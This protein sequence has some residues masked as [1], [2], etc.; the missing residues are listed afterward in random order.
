MATW[1]EKRIDQWLTKRIPPN[2]QYQL[3]VKNT[4]IL[5]TRFGWAMLGLITCLFVL[6]TN[7]Q[8]NVILMF[9]Y[10]VFAIQLLS[11]FHCYT[12]FVQYHVSFREFENYYANEN[13]YLRVSLHYNPN[14]SPLHALSNIAIYYKDHKRYSYLADGHN[15]IDLG[16]F[17]RG[18][19]SIGRVSIESIF[20]FGL[21]KCWTHLSVPFVLLVYPTPLPSPLKLREMN[22]KGDDGNKVGVNTSSEDLQG[23]RTYRETDPIHHV[24]WKHFAKGQGLLTRDFSERAAVS[25]WLDLADYI[26]SDL[27]TALSELTYQVNALSQQGSLFGLSLGKHQILPNHGV[28][29]QSQ[30]LKALA[31]YQLKAVG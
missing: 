10:F 27:E 2:D 29:H 31:N 20:P 30:C 28:D 7:Y 17:K 4:F 12:S 1:K 21:F 14:R 5:P 13:T 8:N 15:N 3:N 16:K 9:C 19:H 18:S 23:L 6:G 22:Q 25:G 11:L 26:H 24:S